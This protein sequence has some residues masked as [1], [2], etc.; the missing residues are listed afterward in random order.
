VA[1]AAE[2]HE[3]RNSGVGRRR[4]SKVGA[5]TNPR[6][7]SAHLQTAAAAGCRRMKMS[8]QQQQ[9]QPQHHHQQAEAAAAALAGREPVVVVAVCSVCNV[10]QVA[11][12]CCVLRRRAGDTSSVTAPREAP[13][14]TSKRLHVYTTTAQCRTAA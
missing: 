11:C 2:I 14:H 12:V 9:Q 3:S 13:V 4:R 8:G 1:C 6:H 10:D 5:W 7:Q